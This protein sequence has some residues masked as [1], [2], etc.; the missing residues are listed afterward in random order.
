ML[1]LYGSQTGSAQEIAES[2]GV[3]L[4]IRNFDSVRVSSLDDYQRENLP[5]EALVVFVVATT[6]DGDPPDNMREFWRFL[7]RKGL[8]SDVLS[9]MRFA[10]LGLGDS[11]YAKYNV[12]GRKLRNRLLQL[13]AVEIATTG[14]TDDQSEH[15]MEADLDYWLDKELWPKLLALYP[16]PAGFVVDTSPKLKP[17]TVSNIT[18]CGNDMQVRSIRKPIRGCYTDSEGN[19]L[20]DGIVIRND[21]IT[22]QDWEQ[23]V[24][25]LE[26]NAVDCPPYVAGDI[27]VVYPE[28][29]IDEHK[30]ITFARRLGIDDL[31]LKFTCLQFEKMFLQPCMDGR[32]LLIRYLDILGTPRRSFFEAMHFFATDED[33]KAKLLEMASSE[34]NDLFHA[35]CKKER[36]SYVDVFDDFK[37]ISLPLEYAIDLIPLLLPRQYSISS[38]RKVHGNN[39]IHL[40]VA[41]LEYITP[42]GR[43]KTGVCSSF[44]CSLSS[45]SV[46]TMGVK[47][48]SLLS[49]SEAVP[50][51]M[52]GPGTGIAPMRSIAYE[53]ASMG[54]NQQY[55]Y[56]GCRSSM[57]D[58]YYKSEWDVLLGKGDIQAIRTAFSRDQKK[59]IYVQ[60]RIKEDADLLWRLLVEENGYCY[61]SGSAARMPSEVREALIEV[62]T[63]HLKEG[64]DAEKLVKQMEVQGRFKIESW[65]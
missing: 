6:G 9:E 64:I 42:W 8:P 28:N 17:P 50:M 16:L 20:F 25:H 40:T 58:F 43:H 23:D 10:V 65:S 34:G 5:D 26:I 52:I 4:S 49:P 46:L 48:G 57:N 37:T 19:V 3:G 13:G 59:K 24:R 27:A 41:I 55:I 53:R 32:T 39:V 33:E 31:D 2:I 56:F 54:F 47:R 61:I 63:L 12:V 60:T 21:R 18:L 29:I 11:S 7:L 22:S 15:G 51:V 30:L 1:V 36:K 62:F 38:C 44:I 35:Y 45:E 14:L